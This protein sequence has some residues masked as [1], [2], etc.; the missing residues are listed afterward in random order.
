[1]E[2]VD[3]QMVGKRKDHRALPAILAELNQPEISDCVIE[4]AESFLGKSE[5]KQN[6][7]PG[8]YVAALKK[9]YSL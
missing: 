3:P 2:G 1:M 4:A 7:R 8:D 6:W 9:Q 5:D